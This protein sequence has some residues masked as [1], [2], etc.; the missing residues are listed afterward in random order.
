MNSAD[1]ARLL[2]GR[3]LVPDDDRAFVDAVRA[4]LRRHKCQRGVGEYR[5]R[6]IVDDEM[7]RLVANDL[8]L[9]HRV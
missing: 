5:P 9:A 2:L 1:L 8:G 4:S 7:V 3:E 6:Y